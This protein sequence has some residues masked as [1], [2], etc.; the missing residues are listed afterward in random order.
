M[1]IEGGALGKA[2]NGRAVLA[3]G[4]EAAGRGGSSPGHV[5]AGAGGSGRRRSARAG[6]ASLLGSGLGTEAL[7]AARRLLPGI[8]SPGNST[9]TEPRGGSLAATTGSRREGCP[10]ARLESPQLPPSVHHRDRLS[11]TGPTTPAPPAAPKK[12]SFAP[13]PREAA[14]R[15]SLS[16]RAPFLEGNR[17]PDSTRNSRS[18][19]GARHPKLILLNLLIGPSRTRR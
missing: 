12:V 4:S 16:C 10:S 11:P 8:I 3:A 17:N 13:F 15:R 1:G 6:K 2:G 5:P 18:R 7:P 19:R 9:G 14:G